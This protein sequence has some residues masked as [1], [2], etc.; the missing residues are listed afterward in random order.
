MDGY[1]TFAQ[2]ALCR[3]WRRPEIIKN[4]ADGEHEGVRRG[5]RARGSSAKMPFELP[6]SEASEDL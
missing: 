6:I 2:E 4:Y 1:S 5:L 3:L